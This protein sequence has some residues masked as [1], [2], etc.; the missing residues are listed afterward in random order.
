MVQQLKES[1][2]AAIIGSAERLF[3]QKGYIAT[4]MADIA[5]DAGVSTGNV[6][7]YFKG[8][9]E[10]YRALIPADFPVYL[11]SLFAERIAAFKGKRDLTEL[12]PDDPY[13]V[14]SETLLSF[15][16]A[17]RLKVIL[18]LKYAAGTPDE[19]FRAELHRLL[20]DMVQE[21]FKAHTAEDHVFSYTLSHVYDHF[22]ANMTAILSDFSSLADIRQA[23][24]QYSAYHLAGL[25]HLFAK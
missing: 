2:R 7:R 9:S 3:A 4:T 18:L 10:L 19:R 1:I 8:K 20:V 21:H 25:K 22:I 12:T 16:I 5:G 14:V 23:V 24:S 11:K 15:C 13:H 6:Y 17:N